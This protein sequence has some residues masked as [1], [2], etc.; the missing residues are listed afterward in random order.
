MV[1][2]R[3]IPHEDTHLAVINFASVAA[4][5]ALHPHRMRAPLR[6]AAGIKGDHTI[7]LPQ[8]LDYL[9]NQDLDQ[10][11]MIPGGCADELLDDQTLNIDEGGD[12]PRILAVQV[13]QEAYQ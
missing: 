6:E 8:L 11:A 13:G 2:A 1:V 5:L 12:L 9:S 10:R 3:H 7:G 4:P